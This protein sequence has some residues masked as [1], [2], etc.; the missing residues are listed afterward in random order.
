MVVGGGRVRRGGEDAFIQGDDGEGLLA[1][2]FNVAFE[3]A[4]GLLATRPGT[5]SGFGSGLGLDL[6]LLLFLLEP[7]GG[8]LVGEGA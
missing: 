3:V 1:E 6:L 4:L 2:D 7:S 8:F 5:G